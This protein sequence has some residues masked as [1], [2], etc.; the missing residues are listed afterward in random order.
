M[1]R[2]ARYT[3]SHQMGDLHKSML[4]YAKAILLLPIH[5]KP[6][7]NVVKAFFYLAFSLLISSRSSNSLMVSNM[8]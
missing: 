3:L 6:S 1:A 7:L 5:T 4:H 2:M 8:L